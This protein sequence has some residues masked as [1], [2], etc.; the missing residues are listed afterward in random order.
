MTP[1]LP[2][3]PSRLP[4]AIL[5]PPQRSMALTL[6]EEVEQDLRN[7]ITGNCGETGGFFMAFESWHR[8]IL[9]SSVF[10]VFFGITSALA[11]YS[12]LFDFWIDAMNE[13][14]FSAG[15]STE[16]NQ[17]RGFLMG[18]LGGTIAGSYMLQTFVVAVPFKRREPWA[19]H[20]VLWPMLLW[21]VVDSAVSVAHGAWFNVYLVNIMPLILFGIP[22]AA[23]RS[24]FK[25]N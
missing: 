23:T 5:H 1:S 12:G 3:N 14:F 18:P 25:A 7:R 17:L 10:F 6:N 15:I 20:A 11:P 2:Q 21:F 16:A 4:K 8:L 24:A 9:Y 19:W 13:A 22:L